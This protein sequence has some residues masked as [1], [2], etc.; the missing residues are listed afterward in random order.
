MDLRDLHPE[1]MAVSTCF[2]ATKYKVSS[3]VWGWHALTCFCLEV[4]SSIPWLFSRWFS[5]QSWKLRSPQVRN[6]DHIHLKVHCNILQRL[7]FLCNIPFLSI[8]IFHTLGILAWLSTLY[9]VQQCAGN[10]DFPIFKISLRISPA[11]AKLW[12]VAVPGRV[13]DGANSNWRWM[14]CWAARSPLGK[15]TF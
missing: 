4:L 7:K 1:T 14:A 13:V 5:G 8:S 10:G 15:S 12:Q 3:M 6:I 9:L 11:L 2:L